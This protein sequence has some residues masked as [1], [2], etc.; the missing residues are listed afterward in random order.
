MLPETTEV[1]IIGA[2][3]S[4]LTLATALQQNGIRSLLVDKLDEGQ[5]TSR[6]VVIHAHTLEVL[7]PLGVTERLLAQGLRCRRFTARD[8]KRILGSLSFDNI[9]SRYNFALLHPQDWT[10]KILLD[11][12]HALGGEVLRP[13]NFVTYNSNED[14]TLTVQL[15]NPDGSHSAVQTRYLVAADGMHS[16]VRTD[17]G[18][19]F[20]GD[21]YEESFVLGDVTL[22]TLLPGDEA[23]LF[24]LP[25]QFALLVPLPNGHWRLVATADQAPPQPDAGFLQQILDAAGPD[26]GMIQAVHWSSRFRVHHRVA[27]TPRRRNILLIG[28]AAHVHS[29]AGGQGMNTG[30]QDATTLATALS[31][32]IA[33]AP[34]S[35]LEE[36]AAHRHK[37]AENVVAFTD[38]LTQMAVNANALERAM[39]RAAFWMLGHVPALETRLA[40]AAAEIHND[41]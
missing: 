15:R 36:W 12:L 34:D 27:Q 35:T 22:T 14:G 10:E 38:R 7:E 18:I 23:F 11:R 8:Q 6:A 4:G 5:N 20:G 40:E 31:S 39:R 9:R 26:A 32:V 3:P 25:G 41:K 17:A 28:D 1:V 19:P 13:Y 37:V 21:A 2:G 29:P 33:G 30:I 24:F 16:A